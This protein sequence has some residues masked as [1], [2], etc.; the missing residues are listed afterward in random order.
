MSALLLLPHQRSAT[1]THHFTSSSTIVNTE[2]GEQALNPVTLSRR[3]LLKTGSLALA[4]L[5][6][7]SVLK[8]ESSSA[9]AEITKEDITTRLEAHRQA[10]Q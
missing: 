9:F 10:N 8:A 6:L 4:G 1:M 2:T 3:E 7:P 5:A